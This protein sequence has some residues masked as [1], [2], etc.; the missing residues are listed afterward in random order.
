MEAAFFLKP[1]KRASFVLPPA[2]SPDRV[3]PA[4]R[5]AH[6]SSSS[7]PPG[8][9][10]LQA[11]R[12][13][14]K[15]GWSQDVSF[16]QEAILE[17]SWELSI[18]HFGN[19]VGTSARVTP[20]HIVRNEASLA[21][22]PVD[23]LQLILIESGAVRGTAGSL[24]YRAEAGDVLISH[25]LYAWELIVEQ[26]CHMVSWMMSGS[27]FCAAQDLS[28]LHGL[29]LQGDSPIGSVVGPHM[30]ALMACSHE[31]S[32]HEAEA[33]GDASLAFIGRLL[34]GHGRHAGSN[35]IGS[36]LEQLCYYIDQRLAAP[37]LGPTHLCR[38]LGLSRSALYR[39]FEPLGG[40][41]MFIRKRRLHSAKR[42]LLDTR[43]RH[44]QI[45]QVARN[46]GLNPETF[47]RLF[48]AAF[49][50]SPRAARKTLLGQQPAPG[51]HT[52]QDLAYLNWLQEL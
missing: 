35:P 15:G 51:L 34:S 25:Q 3:I 28:R 20:Q 24:P 5:I 12:A 8:T 48:H 9:D 50:L 40:V 41:A 22:A 43:Y 13:R 46:H 11:W 33:L 23:T 1:L 38:A 29:V 6:D 17:L 18:H 2:Q 44:L 42:Q 39:Q 26:P 16:S 19:L 36:V 37:E 30:R 49:G 47:G 31:L 7:L 10:R 14:V 27:T 45:A 4:K 52:T 21:S 32:T